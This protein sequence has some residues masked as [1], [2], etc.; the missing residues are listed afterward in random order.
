M[1][2][3]DY[4]GWALK[5]Y[6][7]NH[8][9]GVSE[10]LLGKAHNSGEPRTGHII[11]VFKTRKEAREYNAKHW[12]YIAARSDLREQPHGWSVPRVVKVKI[13]VKEQPHD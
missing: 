4:K 6:S 10:H 2:I 11:N 9:D 12:G 5:W 13:T 1:V 8:V 7:K 3:S